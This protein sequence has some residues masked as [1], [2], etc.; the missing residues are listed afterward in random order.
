MAMTGGRSASKEQVWKAAG[1]KMPGLGKRLSV[2]PNADREHPG[3]SAVIAYLTII[4]MLKLRQM[5]GVQI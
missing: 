4:E 2:I 1:A 3:D 5:A